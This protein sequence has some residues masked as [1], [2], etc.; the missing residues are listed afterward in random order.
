MQY[1]IEKGADINATDPSNATALSLAVLKNDEK[2]VETLIK[3]G[4]DVKKDSSPMSLLIKAISN[5]KKL[6]M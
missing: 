3:N 6:R 5:G 2:V 4:I 1:L